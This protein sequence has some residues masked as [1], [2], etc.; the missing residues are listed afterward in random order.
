[1][2]LPPNLVPRLRQLLSDATYQH[3]ALGQDSPLEADVG[4]GAG[5]RNSGGSVRKAESVRVIMTSERP[6]PLL[7]DCCTLIKVWTNIATPESYIYR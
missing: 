7:E 5:G 3:L 4:D 1:M 2:Q 6:C